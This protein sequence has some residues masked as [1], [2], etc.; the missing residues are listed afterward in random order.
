M[1][2]GS[3][4]I[5]WCAASSCP[6]CPGRAG[7]LTLPF[8]VTGMTSMAARSPLHGRFGAGV[9]DKRPAS[10]ARPP[11]Q[12]QPRVAADGVHSRNL[13]RRIT[14]VELMYMHRPI[15]ALRRNVFTEGIPSDTL[16]VVVV[17]RDL[18][19]DGACLL[20]LISLSSVLFLLHCCFSHHR[21]H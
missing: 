2:S 20:S 1:S 3:G 5:K 4:D 7:R 11:V 16:N 9:P 17:L 19:N 13:R 15:A 6:L 18:S 21:W 10:A 12:V 14:S 8:A